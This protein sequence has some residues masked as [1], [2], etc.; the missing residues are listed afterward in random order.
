MN[1]RTNPLM[2]RADCV[3]L[4]AHSLISPSWSTFLR[5]KFS[6]VAFAKFA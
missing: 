3:E 4:E 1:M 2:R 6:A 5:A